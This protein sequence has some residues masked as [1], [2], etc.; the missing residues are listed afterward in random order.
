MT[1]LRLVARR[2]TGAVAI[3]ALRY[4]GQS[5]SVKTYSRPVVSSGNAN[6]FAPP[7]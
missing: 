5:Q 3:L 6:L 7:M 4:E 1:P 2:Q